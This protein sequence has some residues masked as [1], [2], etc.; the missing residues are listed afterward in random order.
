MWRYLSFFV[1]VALCS[2]GG[3]G[4]S[5]SVPLPPVNYNANG[6]DGVTVGTPANITVSATPSALTTLGST[7]ITAMVLDGSGAKV[8]DGT[9]VRFTLNSNALG[10]MTATST[11]FHGQAIGTFTAANS[12]GTAVITATAGNA[13]GSV[14]VQISPAAI[15]SIQFE[16]ANPQTI[17]IKGFG[18]AETSQIKFI[19]MDVNGQPVSNATVTFTIKGPGGGEYIAPTSVSTT[20]SGE[21]ST[22]LHSGTTAG[23]VTVLATV[24]GTSVSASS[25]AISVGGGTASESHFNL[26]TSV[27]NLPGLIYSGATADISAFVADRYGNYNLLTGTAVSYY[28]EAGA[29]DRTG[30]TDSTGLTKVTLRTQAPVP[31]EVAPL[32]SETTL[33]SRLKSTYGATAMAG[34]TG[35]PRNGWTTV[36]A[37][38]QGEEKFLDENGDGVFTYSYSTTPC[39][40]PESGGSIIYTCECDNGKASV[41]GPASCP[42][43]SKRSEAF[44]DVGEPFIDKNDDG[45]RNDSSTK[46]CNGSVSSSSDPFEEFIDANGDSA[47]NGPNG[48]WD[49]AGCISQ[50][51]QSSKMIPASIT[52]AFTGNPA[53]CA[54]AP[55][56]FALNGGSKSFSFAVGDLNANALIAGTTIAVAADAGTLSGTTDYTILDGVPVGPAEIGFSLSNPSC[57]T[58]DATKPASITVT[59]TPPAP[60]V[61]CTIL[62]PGTYLAD[63]G[64]APPSMSI[65]PGVTAVAAGAPTAQTVNFTVSGGT[66]PYFISSS[67]VKTETFNDDGSGGGIAGD[68]IPNGTESTFWNLASAGQFTVTVPAG[69]GALIGGCTLTVNDNSSPSQS[70]SA[71]LSIQ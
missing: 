42:S 40:G 19:V 46:N 55:T 53:L 2:C 67:C 70:V 12:A 36:L 10:S 68:G 71:I 14:Q 54:A 23:P 7:S 61:G 24:G 41:I 32:T 56:I 28:T 31:V 52:L 63:S 13:Q 25:S 4:S 17:G 64:V 38:V 66:A 29:V 48:V 57:I 39:P 45:C 9:V 30:V 34:V 3:G 60:V 21:A 62:I 18:Q 8:A 26:A 1:L 20:S 35:H 43:G 69:A 6:G 11:T 33:L 49:G 22:I 47:Y 27:F 15:N 58:C 37:T 59:V 50:G 16:S 5:G 65:L 51:C 44:V